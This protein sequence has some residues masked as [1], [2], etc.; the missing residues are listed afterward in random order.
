MVES[1][2]LMNHGIIPVYST[3]ESDINAYRRGVMSF[4]ETGD[5]SPYA[6]Y[7]LNRQIRRINGLSRGT[8]VKF[9]LEPERKIDPP[10]PAFS[11]KLSM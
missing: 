3:N 8:D 6:D 4:Y 5:Y 2:V 1:I 11:R 7:F 10:K 9:E